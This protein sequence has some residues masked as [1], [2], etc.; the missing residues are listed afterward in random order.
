[1]TGIRRDDEILSWFPP[2][3]Q[4]W[5]AETAKRERVDPAVIVREMVREMAEAEKAARGVA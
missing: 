1:M 2:D 3:L 4:R 5:L